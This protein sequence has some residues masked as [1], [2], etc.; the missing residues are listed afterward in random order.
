MVE[1]QKRQA[2]LVHVILSRGEPY[3]PTVWMT[4]DQVENPP[5]RRFIGFDV[6][7]GIAAVSFLKND[8]NPREEDVIEAVEEI[9]HEES[10]L[11]LIPDHQTVRSVA[12]CPEDL[13]IVS[14]W[15]K[16][17]TW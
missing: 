6:H 13:K 7:M 1:F 4:A 10:L 5:D 11:P 16:I 2:Q 17:A 12:R 14:S 15:L 9:S 3:L 8:Q